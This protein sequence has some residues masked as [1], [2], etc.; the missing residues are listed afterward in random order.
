ME[1]KVSQI[2]AGIQTAFIDYNINSDPDFKPQ[3]ISNDYKEGRKVVSA[4]EQ[5]LRN[6]DEFF[7]SVAFI[8]EGGIA[9]LLQTLKEL[10][11]KGIK[12]RILTTDYLTFSEPKALRKLNELSN[13]E[14]RMYCVGTENQGF[15]TKGYMFREGEI[16]KII[17]GSSNLTAKALTINK[18]WN[19][20]IVA[21]TQGEYLR[22]MRIEFNY[23]W[24]KARSLDGWIDTYT[25]IYEE[26]KAITRQT[27][28][29][30]LD[31][32]K[33]E[34]NSMQVSFI[35][36]LNQL[37]AN[38]Q[39]RALLVSATG[40]GKTYASA[41]ALRQ[42]KPKR[43]LFLVHREQIAKQA[44][45]SYQKVFGDTKG[46][47]LISGSSKDMDKELLFATVQTMAKDEVLSSFDKKA[48]DVIVIDEVHRAGAMQ[49]QKVMEY[50]EPNFYLGMTASPERTD[51]FDIFK[52][53]DHNIAY[54]IRLKDAL[55][56][57]LL[58]PFHY[59]GI[60]DLEINGEVFNDSTGL[61]NFTYLVC[62]DRVDYIIEKI[63]YYGYSG[64]RVKGL[65]FCSSKRES[66]ELSNKFNERGYKA[67]DL[68][69]EDSQTA[70]EDAIDRLVS[71]TRD[72]YLDYIFT[73]DIFNEGVDIPEVNQI[74]MLRPTQSP[75]VFVQ[76]L[77]RGLRKSDGKE[78]V[79]ILD[80]I[81]NYTNNFMIPIALSGD[82]SYNKD[83]MRRYVSSGTR[84][85]P[86][87][88]SIHFDEISRKR[89]YNSIDTAKTNNTK[90]LTEAYKNLKYR[91][92]HIPSIMDFDNH[93]SIDPTKIF[94]KFGCYHNFLAKYDKEDYHTVLSDTQEQIL[95]YVSTKFAKG[96]RIHELVLLSILV[97]DGDENLMEKFKS[98][99]KAI[100]NIDVSLEEE[101]SVLDNLNFSFLNST[102]RKK[103]SCS[104]INENS[105]SITDEFKQMLNNND[106]KTQ[107]LEVI[108]FGIS[109]YMINYSDRYNNSNLQLYQKYNYEDV[110]RL[111]NWKQ[112]LTALNIGGYFYDKKTKTLPVFIN[113]E[114]AHD[115]IAYEDRFISNKEL[116][117]F[118]KHPRDINSPDADHIY[119]RTLE[120]KDNKIYLFVRKN[121]DD[122]EAKEFYFLGEINAVGT[123][124]KVL[125]KK[126]NDNAF[127]VTYNLEHPVR[128][129]I[130]EYIVGE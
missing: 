83:T 71:D 52:L 124:K 68:S 51:G 118:S 82:R 27:A 22:E 116:I 47:G 31:Q 126:S 128:E 67:V 66:K 120:D 80:F 101:E 42:M 62:D 100:Y 108:S 59:F 58:C 130:Y 15:H 26:Q 117:A 10:E 99:M 25:Q 48:F 81:G 12:G 13:V 86:G 97:N 9:P 105:L 69:G 64:N 72:D 28:I 49:H 24:D 55:S 35:D 2:E 96:K 57:N 3:F 56:E 40:T 75:I 84:V 46:Y 53:F 30:S 61:K 109:R 79:I 44:L 110:C 89:I 70:R 91:L 63:N 6:C 78:F 43:A 36:N 32:Y 111:L 74:I 125:L 60:S 123:P 76:Q 29:P 104:F 103:F 21:T 87:S 102:D 17:V 11:A 90:L 18:E 45:S 112:N 77:G 65:V 107:L 115:A 39:N 93:G 16:Y 19:T 8:T 38:N 114:K 92:G 50:F 121:K 41:F 5:E 88:S 98:T 127:E 129:D 106:F 33:L 34:P 7:I 94:D 113:Y 20:K 14:V 23:L 95:T 1:K 4:I 37:I 54:E 119:K 85:I 73:V 122:K